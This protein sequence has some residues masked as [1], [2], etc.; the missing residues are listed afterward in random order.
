[1]IQVLH[2]KFPGGRPSHSGA[3]HTALRCPV[4][5]ELLSRTVSGAAL[6][7]SHLLGIASPSN[8]FFHLFSPFFRFLCLF[9]AVPRG[10]P[11]VPRR[12]TTHGRIDS[13]LQRKNLVSRKTF[14]FSQKKTQE[15]LNTLYNYVREALCVSS[16]ILIKIIAVRQSIQKKF[17]LKLGFSFELPCLLLYF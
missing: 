14:S 12:K 16:H 3:P 9:R 13:R 4:S 10:F 17:G 11:P 2:S 7:L 15:I 6:T 1:M 5:K 8:A